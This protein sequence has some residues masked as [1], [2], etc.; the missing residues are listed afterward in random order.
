M[1]RCFPATAPKQSFLKIISESLV[2]IADKHNESV[3][4]SAYVHIRGS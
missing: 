2:D 3:V 4:T 1:G